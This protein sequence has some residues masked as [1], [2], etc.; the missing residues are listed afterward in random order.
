VNGKERILAALWRE[1]PDMVP[2]FEWFVDVTVGEAL[3]GSGNAIDVVERL[4]L[5]AVNIR[6]DYHSKHVDEKTLVDEWGMKRQLTGDVLPALIGSPIEDVTRHAGFEFPDPEA[7]HRFQTLEK[8]ID[9]FGD[10]R[11]VVLNLRDGF[12]D[13]RD[14]LGYEGALMAMLL[15]P[16]RFDELLERSV[17]YNLKLAAVAK[18]RYGTQ[19]I[20]TTDDVAN[21]TGLL[22]RPDTYFERVGPGFKAAIGGYKEQGYL[23]IKHCDG[24]VDTVL[25]FWMDCGIDCLD[26]ID[27][28][29]GYTIGAMKE[30]IGDRVC[31]KGNV[32]CT[33]ALCSGTAEEVAEEV[34]QCI[35]Q[36]ADGGGLIL[37][38]SNTIHRGVKPE[39]FRAMIEA[40]REYGK[41][42]G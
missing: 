24:N 30:R 10:E 38:S 22:M 21:A 9:R 27:P 15:E 17:E 39:N 16:E 12:S 18:E 3:V 1:V 36:G 23:V 19:I 31:L 33:G 4:D 37:S 8:A 13:M 42:P 2:I 14:L 34:R 11:A 35:D 41:Y 7:P 6:A 25:D 20:A 5:D 26:P 32:D 40:A 28:A 29:G